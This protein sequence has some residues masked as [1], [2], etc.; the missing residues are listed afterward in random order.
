MKGNWG[1][2]KIRI[3]KI[4]II[5]WGKMVKLQFLLTH[6]SNEANFIFSLSSHVLIAFLR[7][8]AVPQNI[9]GFSIKTLSERTV[10]F[11][12]QAARTP[13]VPCVSA[14]N[15]CEL[16][17]LHVLSLVAPTATPRHP[18][19]FTGRLKLQVVKW[20][21]KCWTQAQV[22]AEQLQTW[23]RLHGSGHWCPPG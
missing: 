17:A 5:Y 19:G 3:V 7:N 16:C 22:Q 8:W 20:W 13:C 15:S 12:P 2:W 23:G 18:A 11:R 1:I 21:W 6:V 14:P 10:T 4:F 9:R